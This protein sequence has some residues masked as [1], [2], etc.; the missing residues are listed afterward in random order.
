MKIEKVK[1]S[2][3]RNN[4]G[5]IDGL[6]QNPRF[7]KDERFRKL[8]QSIKDDPEFMEIREIVAYD[9]RGQLVVVGGNMR[10]K[11][12]Q[13][14]GIEETIVKIL[15]QSMPAEKLRAFTIKD[16]VAF[17]S[18]DFDNLADE[19]NDVELQ[20]FGM[21]I[22]NFEFPD[23][24]EEEEKEESA[25]FGLNLKLPIEYKKDFTSLEKDTIVSFLISKLGELKEIEKENSD[26]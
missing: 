4:T 15:P 5:Q 25:E 17:G 23:E 12:L 11:A 7:I 2:E 9:N 6:P 10:L 22:P 14:L 24:E 13:E 21:E 18:D 26:E 19:W 8:V 3:L 20:A 1:V 16:N